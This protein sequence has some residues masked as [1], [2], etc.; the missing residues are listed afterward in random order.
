MFCNVQLAGEHLRVETIS[1][2]TREKF[3]EV[4]PFLEW[5]WENL[6]IP[7]NNEHSISCDLD[8]VE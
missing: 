8:V 3:T 4:M 2:V 1:Y 5:M 7:P 6:Y